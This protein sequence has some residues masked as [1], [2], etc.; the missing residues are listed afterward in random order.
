[1]DPITR[2]IM[3][4]LEAEIP[5]AA[6]QQFKTTLTQKF[7]A[8]SEVVNALSA[9]EARPTSFV[10]REALMNELQATQATQDKSLL[11]LVEAMQLELVAKQR[12]RQF[13][14][15]FIPRNDELVQP[16]TQNITLPPDAPVD[17]EAQFSQAFAPLGRHRGAEI[18]SGETGDELD[19][20]VVQHGRDEGAEILSVEPGDELETLSNET[21]VAI[22]AEAAENEPEPLPTA[23]VVVKWLDMEVT[24]EEEDDD[25]IVVA[26][27][28]DLLSSLQSIFQHR[29]ST[30]P[31][32]VVKPA[33]PH[34]FMGMAKGEVNV[35]A[36]P[37]LA[38]IYVTIP[39]APPIDLT[40]LDMAL[41]DLAELP[42]DVIPEITPLP[43]GS[44][45]PVEP[46]GLFLGRNQELITIAKAIKAH[47]T[48]VINQVETTLLSAKAEL[49]S[50]FGGIG[51][52]H[53]ASEFVHR[54]GQYFGGGVFW[55]NFADPNS[56]PVEIVASGGACASLIRADFRN[57][58]LEE[59]MQLVLSAWQSSLPRLLVFD[60]CEDPELLNRWQ[61]P[62]GGC[63]V[64]VTSRQADWA[65]VPNIEQLRLDVL[66][67]RDSVSLLRQYRP[68][69]LIADS[70]MAA[71]AAELGHL[72]LALH[73]AGSFLM[74]Y[75]NEVTPVRYRKR[76]RKFNLA[77]YPVLKTFAAQLTE[78]DYHLIRTFML[79]YEQLNTDEPT[80]V[81]AQVILLRAAF[82]A[83]NVMIPRDLLLA[84][85]HHGSPRRPRRDFWGKLRG[86]LS[87]SG[88][89]EMNQADL[90]PRAKD[91]L[92]RLVILGLL[93]LAQDGALFLHPFLSQLLRS[94]ADGSEAQSM[95][96]KTLAETSQLLKQAGSPTALLAWQ[97]HLRIISELAG[98]E[99]DINLPGP[100]GQQMLEQSG[101]TWERFYYERA[102]AINEQLLGENHPDTA[103]SL[104]NLGILASY[105]ADYLSARFYFERAL[106]IRLASLGE[107][108]PDTARSFNNYGALLAQE[109]SY[110]QA[111]SYYDKALVIRQTVLG[112]RHPDTAQS[113]HNLGEL[114][115][116]QENY[117][118]AQQYLEQA[119]TIYQEVLGAN[120]P[121]TGRTWSNLGAVCEAQ[122]YFAAARTAYEMALKI[123]RSV[124][125]ENHVD[126]ATALNNLGS[127]FDS[128]GAYSQAA[129]YYEAALAIR[130]A[131][132]GPKHPDTAT[133][134]HNLGVL[135]A[136]ANQW[137]A[138]A[139]LM[140][141]ALTLRQAALGPRHPQVAL[142]QECL[143]IIEGNLQRKWQP[144]IVKQPLRQAA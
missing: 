9:L 45:M 23:E 49:T 5:S 116:Q 53:L 125:G 84:T 61:P 98:E 47:K 52:T 87:T 126:T 63:H 17:R 2:A 123:F 97:P 83:P 32:P 12:P 20:S 3:A 100:F 77:K 22:E 70:D 102:L 122:G 1:M 142:S 72:P 18:L 16:I 80:D 110:A 143:A 88:G 138:A 124:M 35:S 7:G 106:A 14:E 136:H 24:G 57:L 90:L 4:I 131:I 141:Q 92:A 26:D 69:P 38:N 13:V 89:P 50:E 104:D 60:N 40:I 112:S 6:Y 58:L 15:A 96:K 101:Q 42:L 103:Q 55:L 41:D 46:N 99:D 67:D 119:L 33:R 19:K 93:E 137:E 10:R 75:R 79:S 128:Q 31:T 115:Y 132:L 54:Y 64:I 134:L 36:A 133:S 25:E 139:T 68:D 43:R 74:T 76:L 144:Q 30:K 129:A 86:F 107:Q 105:Q 39:S 109:G 28:D 51:K 120:H 21:M 111:K 117:G 81:L 130:E 29:Q 66:S 48:V 108:H 27:D 114:S 62:K 34:D 11:S 94:L 8:R 37:K 113:L 73:L 44:R 71:I 82:F 121:E 95:V 127:L 85:L 65:D 118:A 140:R 59:Q 91:A 56:I 135:Q 78:H